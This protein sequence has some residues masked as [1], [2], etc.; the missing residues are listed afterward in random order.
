MKIPKDL[1]DWSEYP[2]MVHWFSPTVLAKVIKKVITSKMFAQYADRRLVHASLDSPIDETALVERCGGPEGLCAEKGQPIWVD[3][4][5]DLGDGF[6]STYAVAYLIGQKELDVES[7]ALPRAHCLIM[8]GDE[9]YPDASRNDYT[10][11][12]KRPYECAFPRSSSKDAERPRAFLIPGNHDWYDG[13]TLFLAY[14]CRGRTTHLG[15]WDARQNRSYFAVH[16]TNNWWVWGYDSQLGEDID[17]PQADY[18]AEVARQMEPGAKVILCASVP[19]W[20]KADMS[21]PDPSKQ[22]EYY[23]AL[24]YIA[25]ILRDECH[26]AKVPLV[27]SGDLHHY[28][29]YVAEESGTNFITAGG[30]GAFLHPTHHLPEAIH[31]TWA[32]SGQHLNLAEAPS[33]NPEEPAKACYPPR[34]VSRKLA[35]G[36]LCFIAKNADFC[37][38]LGFLYWLSGLIM[39]WWQGYGGKSSG[40][41]W[42]EQMWV[43]LGTILPTPTFVALV[44]AYMAAIIHYADIK[45]VELKRIVG[46]AHALLHIC[47]ATLSTAF[48]STALSSLLE[49]PLGEIL[50]FAGLGI[51]VIATGFAGGLVWRL[52]LLL[53]SWIW[54]MHAN[55]AFSAMRLDSYR[56]FLR[57]KIDGDKLTVYPIGIDQ[58]PKRSDW[59]FDEERNEDDQNAPII[60]PMRSLGQKFIEGPV[61]LDTSSI[62][63]LRKKRIA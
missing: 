3:Y 62:E 1:D 11:R 29:R 48:F 50:Y 40:V 41:G 44:L 57:L 31:L 55:D 52:Y 37:L 17:K 32:K 63:P 25:N 6:D 13:L 38:T 61:T 14:F 60:I 21:G 18:F 53:A 4:V 47:I 26:G 33:A 10:I 22:Q 5:S 36:N 2:G 16:L 15:S 49:L 8:G 24:D 7:V 12:M 9:V 34:R 35:W 23:R 54:A 28:S 46:G 45:P 27:L 58:S 20:L 42:A 43:Q 39:L 19:A 30:G 56:H 51:G 59:K